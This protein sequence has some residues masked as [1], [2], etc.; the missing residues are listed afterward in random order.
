MPIVRHRDP[1][2]CY[3]LCPFLFWVIIFVAA[4]RYA[5]EDTALSF[6]LDAMKKETSTAISTFPLTLHHVN[7]LVLLCTWRSPDVRF[8]TDRSTLFPGIAMNACLLLGIH[9]GQGRHKEHTV[10]Q[11]TNE[12]TDEEATFTWAG[13]N[14]V[15]QRYTPPPVHSLEWHQLEIDM[16]PGWLLA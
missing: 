6:L 14:I 16:L 2:K 11:F 7:A 4:R 9:L 10:G 3:D 8:V 15:S 13:Y 5:R 12:F 1:N